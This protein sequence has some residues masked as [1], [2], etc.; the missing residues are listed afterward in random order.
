[1]KLMEIVINIES[2]RPVAHAAK[3]LSETG[4]AD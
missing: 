2:Q 3:A 4:T 1:M